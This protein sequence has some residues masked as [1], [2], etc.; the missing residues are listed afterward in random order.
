MNWA[1]RAGAVSQSLGWRRSNPLILMYH[2]VT[3]TR[4][5]D[6]MF[7]N[8][9][10]KHLLLDTFRLQLRTI[11]R[12]RRVI[13][14][15]EMVEGLRSGDDLH[16]TISITFDDGYE[17]NVLHAAPALADFDMPAAFF[18]CTGT[19]GT[20]HCM[21]TDCVE[22][23]LDRTRAGTVCLPLTN[24]KLPLHSLQDKRRALGTIKAALKQLPHA[25][26]SARLEEIADQLNVREVESD[27]DYNFMSWDQARSLAGAG[28]EI[29]AHTVNHPILSRI[30]LEE[31]KNEILASRD[32][33]NAELGQCSTT[34]CYPNGGPADYT[35]DI[36]EFCK[37]HF[38]AAISTSRGSADVSELYQLRRLGAPGAGS[39]HSHIEWILLRE[40]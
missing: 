36:M 14:L 6:G 18:L 17:N 12:W 33:I 28:F 40:R 37:L 20:K 10:E 2:G 13:P 19:I 22:I 1:C 26:L 31:A 5:A 16:N 3:A 27:G 25:Q 9:D 15:H 30:P 7:R 34:F 23:M 32:K 35:S 29:G 11:Q 38:R 24:Q 21:W 8:C 4:K 39:V